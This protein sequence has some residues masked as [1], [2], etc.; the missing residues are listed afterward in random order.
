M[1]ATAT[2]A[3]TLPELADGVR[4]AMLTSAAPTGL[5]A[6]PL[7]VQR[8]DDDR[9]WFLVARDAEWVPATAGHPVN[10]T[11]TDGDRWVSISGT[12]AV[13]T[14]PGVLDEL[15]D[16]I[17]DAWFGDEHQPAAL[18]IDVDHGDWWASASAPRVAIELVKA[19]LTGATPDTGARGTVEV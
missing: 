12:A 8:V 4:I 10:V 5:D 9:V 7:T 2:A 15:G 3:R 18:R 19:R 13:V 1:D 6:R 11:M 14:D 16:P 17:S